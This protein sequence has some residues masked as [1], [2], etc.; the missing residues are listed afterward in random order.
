MSSVSVVLS[1]FLWTKFEFLFSFENASYYNLVFE[2][3][4]CIK[5]SD[6]NL[7][8]L[9]STERGKRDVEN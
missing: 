1:K 8:G 5:S 7:I 3:C 6:F 9:F 2:E 4:N